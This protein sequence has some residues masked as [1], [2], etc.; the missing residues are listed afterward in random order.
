MFTL[1]NFNS[2]RQ[3][4]SKI[5]NSKILFYSLGIVLMS[6]LVSTSLQA[7]VQQPF[8]V[9]YQV[10]QK[11]SIAFLSNGVVSCDLYCP[12]VA[13]MPPGG[14]GTNNSYN[15]KYINIDSALAPAIFMASSDSLNLPNCS[16]ISW[17]GLYWG[18]AI[19]AAT[20]TTRNTAKLKVNNGS[21]IDLTADS[22]WDHTTFPSYH[23][24]KNITSIVKANNIKA[25]YTLANIS[26]RTTVSGKFGGWTIVVV[27]KNDL[28]T[29]R[30]LTVSTGLSY[31]SSGATIT[32]IPVTGF[33]TPPSGPVN[34]ELGMVTYDGDRGGGNIGDSLLFKGGASFVPISNTTNPL[35]DIYNSTITNDGALT[36]FRNP[37]HNNT[38]GYDADIFKPNNA[39][40]N[41]IGNGATSATIRQTTSTTSGE[42]FLTQVVTSAIDVYEPDMRV[43]NTVVDINGGLVQAGDTLEYTLTAKNLGNDISVNTVVY[44]TLNYNIDFVPG[45]LKVVKGPNSGLK[46][47]GNDG[48]QAEYSPA[49][50]IVLFRVGTGANG[51]T[52]GQ[53]VNSTLG[54]DSTVVKFRVTAAAECVKLMC[55]N[56]IPNRAY[57]KGAGLISGNYLISSSNPDA[58][59]AFGCP[60]RGT[61]STTLVVGSCPALVV[62]SN[63]PV[64]G[65]DTIKLTT[66]YSANAIYSW[67]GPNSFTS[68][69]Q[70]P[71]IPNAT[72]AMAGVYTVVISF[73]GVACTQSASTTVVVNVIGGV[74]ASSA[75]GAFCNATNSATIT[76]SGHS[77]SVVK[78]QT[79]TTSGLT[80]TDITNT[81]TTYAF[82]NAAN[83]QQY[84][85]VVSNGTCTNFSAATT[86]IVIGGAT[87]YTGGTFCSTT[88][89]GTISLI[90]QSTPSTVVRWETSTNG[91]VSWSN[92]TNTTSSYT[93]TNAVNNQ[94]YRAIVNYNA[95]CP[96]SQSGATTITVSAATSAGTTAYSGLSPLCDKINSGTITLSGHSG[97][98]VKWQTSTDLG[99]TWKDINNTTASYNFYNAVNNQKYR[100]AVSCQT[101]YSTIT[102][103]TA[104]ATACVEICN[105]GIDNDGDGLIDCD[106]PD[107]GIKANTL[108]KK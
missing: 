33:L 10:Q 54:I 94:Q 106:D 5:G 102:T 30:N 51:S 88:N 82:T 78:W 63:S 87:S 8:K 107:C 68:T 37:S 80:W 38:L 14:T 17:A 67:T 13:E 85:A 43:V 77:G 19:T 73:S 62:G 16:E 75:G 91:G 29:M 76:L 101:N 7:Q 60:V 44:D 42:T 64:C 84:R 59:D 1:F 96:A 35:N 32:D 12:A 39:A 55:D 52:G 70:N 74:T 6:L 15:A 81:T 25:R 40:K 45:S 46:T 21:Y 105:D 4:L 31:V 72:A 27:Y 28:M 71:I 26:A 24:F 95:T 79:S 103:I 47:D 97:S 18:A 66:V 49:T 69:L 104:N 56:T 86:V 100:A 22:L 98:I 41:Y 99:V 50:R 83:N 61:T 92:I 90:G 89:S 9:Q 34:F 48:D 57:M 3:F 20:G 58:F 93:F 36:P 65:A 53:V 108:I 11:G 2:M 23:C